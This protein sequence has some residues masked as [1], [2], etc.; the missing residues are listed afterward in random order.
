MTVLDPSLSALSS[1]ISERFQKAEAIQNK[2][3][4]LDDAWLPEDEAEVKRL[5]TEV[6]ALEAKRA[7]MESAAQRQARIR[8][9]V[10]ASTR[11][12][13]QHT[14][15]FGDP[16]GHQVKDIGQVFTESR[17]YRE[18]KDRGLFN[19]ESSP[20]QFTVPLPEGTSL[21]DRAAGKA[22][23]YSGTGVGGPMITPDYYPGLLDI[24]QRELTLLDLIPRGRTGSDTISYLKEKTFT[25]A[26]AFVAEATVTTGTTGT[27]PESTLEFE[28]LTENVSTLAHWIPVT[29]KMLADAPQVESIIRNRLLLGL[30]L[31]LETQI[32]SGDNTGENFLGLIDANSGIQVQAIGTDSVQDAIFKALV[33]VRVTGLSRPNAVVLHPNDFSAVRLARENSATGTLGGY[34][35]GPPS[36]TGATTLWGLPVVMSLGITENTGLVGDFSMGCMLFDREQAQLRTGWI[37]DQF[38]RNMQTLLAE[39]RAAF[40]IWR[41]NSFCKI[42]GI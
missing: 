34:L 27:K 3:P 26:A 2:Y 30:D 18:L 35:M 29:N 11:P 15:S 19:S 16:G 10:A 7:T 36:Q 22:L 42:T 28:R 40:V 9:G 13:Q 32:I 25:N 5:L 8:D 1:D 38:V 12:T 41:P 21:L 37:N 33:K 4:S 20:I 6:D 14:Q 24:L 23:V 39:L 17:E 31:T